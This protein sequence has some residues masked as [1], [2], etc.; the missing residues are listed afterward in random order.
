MY[1]INNVSQVQQKCNEH[2]IEEVIRLGCVQDYNNS[3][4]WQDY[5]TTVTGEN[6]IGKMVLV[7]WT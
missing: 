3:D 4:N 2:W 6:L 1:D 7:N 5:Y